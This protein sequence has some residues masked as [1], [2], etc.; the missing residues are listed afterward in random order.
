MELTEFIIIGAIVSAIVQFIKQ[1]FGTNTNATLIAVISLSIIAGS[2]YYFVKD[3][4]LW[5]PIISILGF[6]GAVYA[7]I[8]KRFQD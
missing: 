5:V 1:K 4:Q 8:I 7:F 2:A 6:A 3:T